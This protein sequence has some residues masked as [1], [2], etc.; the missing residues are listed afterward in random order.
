MKEMW[1]DFMV[2]IYTIEGV[3]GARHDTIHC[4]NYL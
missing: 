1:Q 4:K 2:D 3:N